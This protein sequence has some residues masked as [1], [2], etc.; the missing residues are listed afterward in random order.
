M[1]CENCELFMADAIGDELDPSQRASFS[2]HLAQCPKCREE[3]ESA[4]RA[5]KTMRELPGPR[6]VAVRREGDR[7]VIL[8][9][10]TARFR[11]GRLFTGGV[12]RYAASVLIAFAAGY[13]LHAGWMATDTPRRVETLRRETSEQK[14]LETG[15][16]LQ[17]ALAYAHNRSPSS[18]HLAKAL[19]AVARGEH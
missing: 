6:H 5:V 16:D 4:M 7:L 2:A 14:E 8:G 15:G 12:F 17:G 10:P 9:Q 3:Y 19:M 13:A 1:N 11:L 18:S